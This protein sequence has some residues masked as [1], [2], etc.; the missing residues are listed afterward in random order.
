MEFRPE[1]GRSDVANAE[2]VGGFPCRGQ[3]APQSALE[4][5]FES[6]RRIVKSATGAFTIPPGQRRI[7]LQTDEQY[8]V[9]RH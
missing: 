8:D 3:E 1:K 4:E 6:L 5:V 9:L 2:W 7:G